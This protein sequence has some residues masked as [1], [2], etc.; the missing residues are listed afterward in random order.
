[1]ECLLKQSCPPAEII[2]VDDGSDDGTADF[3]HNIFGHQIVIISKLHGGPASARNCGV[4]IASSEFIAFT[5]SDC[6]PERDWLEEL[7][8]GFDSANVAGCGGAVRRADNDL[9]SEFA[10][11][12]GHFNATPVANEVDSLVTANACF[13]RH[14]LLEAG[15][16]DERFLKAGG[17][18]TELSLRIRR[19]GYQFRF[20]A[21]AIV[22]HHHHRTLPTLLR[23]MRNHGEATHLLCQLC[24][25][26]RKEFNPYLRALKVIFAVRSMYRQGLRYHQD[27]GLAKTLIFTLLEDYSYLANLWGYAQARRRSAFNS[28]RA[29]SNLS[30][31]LESAHRTVAKAEEVYESAPGM[32]SAQQRFL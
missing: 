15:L 32:T 6:L 28:R 31:P 24:P 26:K 27:Y 20:V 8:R 18:D 11:A 21:S 9:L 25:D 7:L 5:D 30:L 12:T 17:E 29:N 19:L 13:R 23:T 16:F 22:L 14:A 2:V 3:L 4:K 1:V 10:D